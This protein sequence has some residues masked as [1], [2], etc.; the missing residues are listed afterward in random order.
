M[1]HRSVLNLSASPSTVGGGTCWN[2]SNVSRYLSARRSI[3]GERTISSASGILLHHLN[4][5]VVQTPL[6]PP[7]HNHGLG[8]SAA[9]QACSRGTPQQQK[10]T[11]SGVGSTKTRDEMGQVRVTG[12]E[13]VYICSWLV[14]VEE[15]DR[16]AF[17]ATIFT[18]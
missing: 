17:R 2:V 9:A 8:H 18:G 11:N 4:I 14:V 12:A 5:D 3:P 1:A 13:M 7:T 6:N 16:Q 10:C 15:S